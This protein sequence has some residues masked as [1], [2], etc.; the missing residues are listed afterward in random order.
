LQEGARGDIE[1]PRP[2]GGVLL[3]DFGLDPDDGCEVGQA[4]FAGTAAVALEP[5]DLGRDGD[6]ALLDAAVA[7]VD[8]LAAVGRRAVGVI[9]EALD[10]AHE[11]GLA[12]AHKSQNT[13][14][15][16]KVPRRNT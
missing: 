12:R 11:A 5:I 7:L 9:E 8:V 16:M 2:C 15:S 10:F 1:A 14:S 3:E 13:S 6:A 4:V